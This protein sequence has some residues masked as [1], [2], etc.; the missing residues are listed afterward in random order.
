MGIALALHVIWGNDA[1]EPGISLARD[2]RLLVVET[3]VAEDASFGIVG[4]FD[5]G[6]AMDDSVGLVEVHRGRNIFRDDCIALPRFGDAIDLHGQ[7]HRDADAIQLACEMHHRGV[8]LALAEQHDVSPGLFRVTQHTV[9]I[10]IEPVKDRF[11]RRLAMAVL[12]DFDESIF[13]G[14]LLQTPRDLDWTVVRIIMADESAHE[15]HQNVIV[16]FRVADTAFNRQQRWSSASE[17][18][19]HAD[20][21]TQSDETKH[22]KLLFHR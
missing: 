8:A 14:I 11:E 19:E 4:G 17:Q 12:E 7:H 2:R 3:I 1:V 10:G 13:G 9:L 5:F 15:T 20:K 18:Q 6:P 16:R 21:T 22:A